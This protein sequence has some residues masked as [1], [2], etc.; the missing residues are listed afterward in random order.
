MMSEH[1]L[2]YFHDFGIC[3]YWDINAS[4]Q[5]LQTLE[6]FCCLLY[7][8][9]RD[10]WWWGEFWK[11]ICDKMGM[12]RALTTAYH[13]QADRQMEIINQALEISLWDY[14]GPNKDNWVSSLNGLS[15]SYNSTPH[16]YHYQFCTSSLLTQRIC[17]DNQLQSDSFSWKYIQIFKLISSFFGTWVSPPGGRCIGEMGMGT[18]QPQAYIPE[19]HNEWPTILQYLGLAWKL[20]SSDCNRHNTG[21]FMMSTEHPVDH[22]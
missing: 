4:V 8:S 16:T 17:S 5:K 21:L 19:A 7:V 22:V 18:K 2:Y 6:R 15:L 9:D 20:V 10:T 11:E 1:P 3:I 13:P 12:K 14:M